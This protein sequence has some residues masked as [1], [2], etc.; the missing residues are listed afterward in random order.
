MCFRW[1]TGRS[2]RFEPGT[3]EGV[4]KLLY[5]YPKFVRSCEATSI[6]RAPDSEPLM[7]RQLTCGPFPPI[8]GFKP[9]RCQFSRQCPEPDGL[10]GFPSTSADAPPEVHCAPICARAD[11]LPSVEHVEDGA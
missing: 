9:A 3:N 6:G 8:V 7:L 2:L 4:G 1:P 5:E 11:E 10:T